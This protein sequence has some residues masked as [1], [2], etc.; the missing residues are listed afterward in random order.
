MNEIERKIK[1]AQHEVFE[2]DRLI[3]RKITIDDAQEM[4]EFAGDPAVPQ[5]VGF[6]RYEDLKRAQTEIVNL[7]IPNRLE[8]WGI[9]YKSTGQLIGMLGL[10]LSGTQ[11]SFW[12]A[13][14]QKFWGQ[15]LMPEAARTLRDFAFDELELDVLTA[16]HYADNPKSGRVMAKIG[17]KK[18]GQIWI[19]VRKVEKSVLADYW[20]LT[21]EEYENY[22]RNLRN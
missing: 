3:L 6:S 19:Y 16:D 22:Q 8:T 11:A 18:L 13:L 10:H 21:R 20:A 12:W 9:V 1:L 5:G 17:M 4:L 2:T 7:S 14:H 15:G